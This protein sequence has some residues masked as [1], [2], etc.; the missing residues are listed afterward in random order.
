[1]KKLFLITILSGVF[2]VAYASTTFDEDP[3]V[4]FDTILYDDSYPQCYFP[5]GMC[6]TYLVNENSNDTFRVVIENHNFVCYLNNDSVMSIELIGSRDYMWAC[7]PEIR[8]SLPIYLFDIGSIEDYYEIGRTPQHVHV[9]ERTSTILKDGRTAF[10]WKYDGNRPKDIEYIGSV[11]GVLFP[12]LD[13]IPYIT[14]ESR[15]LQCSVGEQL[16]YEPKPLSSSLSEVQKEN[17]IDKVVEDGQLII[18]K[19]GVRYNAT[20]AVLQ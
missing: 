2:C 4:D 5:E 1:M 17:K 18:L 20:G 6:W 12:I 15:F 14:T 11:R 13:F 9:I 10:V 19:D 3:Y 16:L 8:G 7:L